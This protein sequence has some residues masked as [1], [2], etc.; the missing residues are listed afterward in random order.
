VITINLIS[1]LSWFKK[2]GS[3]EGCE[4]LFELDIGE[5]KSNIPSL[6]LVLLSKFQDTGILYMVGE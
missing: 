3:W 5:C 2:H 4:N 1:Y 6:E